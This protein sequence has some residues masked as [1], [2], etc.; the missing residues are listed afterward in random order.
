MT[1]WLILKLLY[2]TIKNNI[3][4]MRSRLQHSTEDAMMAARRSL[5]TALDDLQ[6]QPKLR[7]TLEGHFGKVYSMHWAGDS[8]H[9]V[10]ASQD[11][12]LIVWNAITNNKVHSIPLRSSWVMTCAFE[13]TT[14]DMVA[15]GGLDNLY[16]VVA[17]SQY[18]KYC[19]EGSIAWYIIRCPFHQ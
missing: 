13:E 5:P 12:K 10:S 1:V 16:V 4:A 3:D 18:G 14:S 15:C 6:S 8:T 2:R 11:G 9:L 17:S 7:R 19:C